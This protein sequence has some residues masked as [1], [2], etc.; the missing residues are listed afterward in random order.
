MN[1][2]QEGIVLSVSGSLA[3]VKTSRH[4][5]CENCGSCPGN[6]AIVLDV[7]N[8]IGARPGQLVV[9][10]VQ[11]LDMLKSAFIVYMLPLIAIFGG[12]MLGGY[13]AEQLAAEALL[14]QVMGGLLAFVGSIFYIRKFDRS[15]GADVKKQPVIIRI[16]TQ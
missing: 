6:T 11:E 2:Q 5:D 4:T 8:Q 9:V 15:A 12:T 16:L 1:T 3:K 14:Y 10:E 7:V 13:I